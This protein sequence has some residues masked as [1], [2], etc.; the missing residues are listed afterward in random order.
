MGG[1]ESSQSP[2]MEVKFGIA[3]SPQEFFTKVIAAYHPLEKEADVPDSLKR[4]IVRMLSLGKSCLKDMESRLRQWTKRAEALQE[5]EATLHRALDPAVEGIVKDKKIILFKEMLK[6]IGYPDQKITELIAQGFP[7]S[8]PL[9]ITGV[10][11]VR[12]PEEVVRGADLRWLYRSAREAQEN[13]IEQLESRPADAI[14]E[15]VYRKTAKS[16]EGNPSELDRHWL[17]GPFTREELDKKFGS[18][19]W[20][21]APRFGTDKQT[22]KKGNPKVRVIDDFSIMFQNAC[23]TCFE[24]INVTGVDGIASTAKFWSDLVLMA[25]RNRL[26]AFST[27]LSTGERLTG[28]LHKDFRENF[29]LVGQCLDLESAYRQLAVRPSQKHLAVIGVLNT[30]TGK[31]EFFVMHALPFGASSAAHHFNRASEAL[32]AVLQHSFGVPCIHYFDDFTF[33]L[34]EPLARQVLGT[35]E[36]VFGLLGWPFKEER[37]DLSNP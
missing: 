22:D 37:E 6:F 30:D 12:P 18:S 5:E 11:G 19:L 15:E 32:E 31:A 34:P 24:K 25:R 7:I 36:K 21:P 20:V 9:D 29:Q 13:V 33:L 23:T 4:A 35:V 1:N 28:T 27:T 17:E 8:G 26:W 3:H 14:L 2:R 16:S 10:F